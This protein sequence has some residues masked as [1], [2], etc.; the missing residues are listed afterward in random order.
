MTDTKSTIWKLGSMAFSILINFFFLTLHS[1]SSFVLLLSGFDEEEDGV[2]RRNLLYYLESI[3]HWSSM[4]HCIY[5][6][7]FAFSSPVVTCIHS[8]QLRF[9]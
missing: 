9:I 4:H 7:V 8:L 3:Y 1:Y 6:G 5:L 2:K